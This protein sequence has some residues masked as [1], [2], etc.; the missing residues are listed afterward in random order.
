MLKKAL[1]LNLTHHPVLSALLLILSASRFLVPDAV[2]SCRF[3][4]VSPSTWNDFPIPRRKNTHLPCWTPWNLPSFLFQKLETCNV[5]PSCAAIFLCCKPLLC[6]FKSFV[7]SIQC[8][9][10]CGCPCVCV[11]REVLSEQH[12]AHYIYKYFNYHYCSIVT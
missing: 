11:I 1:N 4:I 9:H 2:G 5:F 8:T 3:S 7:N 6:L 10:V 12:F